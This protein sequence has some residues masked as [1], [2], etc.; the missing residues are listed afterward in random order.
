L[1]DYFRQIEKC[2]ARWKKR[3]RA[4]WKTI[5]PLA[6]TAESTIGLADVDFFDTL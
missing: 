3:K 5:A 1:L 4:N 6:A 2:E